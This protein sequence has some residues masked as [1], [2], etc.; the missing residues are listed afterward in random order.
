MITNFIAINELY[1]I[2]C[3][4]HIIRVVQIFSIHNNYNLIFAQISSH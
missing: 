2:Y 1:F 4:F 3:T